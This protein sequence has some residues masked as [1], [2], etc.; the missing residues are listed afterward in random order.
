MAP[1]AQSLRVHISSPPEAEHLAELQARLA[2]RIELTLGPELPANPAYEILVNGRPTEAE[3]TASASLTAVVIPWAGVART[4]RDLLLSHARIAVHNLHY[5]DAATAE[6]AVTLML[7]AAKLI[8]PADR[9]LRANNWSIRYGIDPALQVAGKTAVVLGYGSIGRRVAR[10]CQGLEMRVLA[11]RRGADREYESEGVRVF[12]ANRLR[13]LLKEADVLLICLP[14]T[15]ETQGL[16][17]AAELALLPP[18]AVLVNVGRGPIVDEAALFEAL[19]SGRL[20]AAGI[21]VWYQYP[22]SEEAGTNTAP[23]HFPFA[24]LQNVVLSPHRGGDNSETESIRM[25]ALAELLNHA[26]VGEEMPNRVD[27]QAG[28]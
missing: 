17:A 18:R 20:Y 4:T 3:M 19:K 22:R 7:A 13:D 21:D 9:D 10:A 12:P 27:L 24:E 26:A 23:G 1:E 16:I 14:L 28:Y 25:A 5:N 2:A 6:M 15:P 8:V 11:L